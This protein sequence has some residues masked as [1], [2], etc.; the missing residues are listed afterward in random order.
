[1]KEALKL[2]KRTKLLPHPDDSRNAGWLITFND[3]VT[4]ILTFFILALSMS[5]MNVM[6]IDQITRAI[7][8]T[9]GATSAHNQDVL[10]LHEQNRESEAA[11][12][13]RE[14]ELSG[15]E[16]E[17]ASIAGAEA[18]RDAGGV[19]VTMEEKTLFDPGSATL[20]KDSQHVLTPLITVLKKNEM[21]VH[22]EGHTDSQQIAS[23]LFASNW[24]L[25]IDR[26]VNVAMFLEES[27]I[28]ANR[29]SVVGYGDTKPVTGNHNFSGRQKNRRV[30]I[31]LTY[32]EE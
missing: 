3:M 22:V 25:S 15:L 14:Q 1:M 19:T 6:K 28:A 7:Q 21:L 5:D 27:G 16:V 29:L 2:K 32:R 20:K 24:D 4:I 30:E 11:N 8:E 12:A 17:I 10:T 13:R 31:K 26:A 18:R 9:F 23:T